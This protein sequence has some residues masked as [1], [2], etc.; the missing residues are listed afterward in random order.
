MWFVLFI[1]LVYCVVLLCIITF[2]VPCCDVHYALP[3]VVCRIYVVCVCLGIVVSNTSCVVFLFCFSSF[4]VPYVTSF[5]VLSFFLL[6]LR[7]S[8][9]FMLDIF[10]P[11]KAEMKIVSSTNNFHIIL[12]LLFLNIWCLRAVVPVIYGSWIYNYLCNQCLSPLMLWVRISIRA[13]CTTLCDKVCQW[14]AAGR[15]FPPGPPVSSTKKTYRH[16]ITEILLKVVLNTNKQ[17]YDLNTNLFIYLA[18][19]LTHLYHQIKL[20]RRE[21]IWNY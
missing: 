16:D 18:Q 10:S 7:Y 19:D 1:F 21:F 9:T 5:S 12:F 11:L 17:T 13:R 2:S 6:P 4:C 14:L 15:W 20:W 8:L 3:P